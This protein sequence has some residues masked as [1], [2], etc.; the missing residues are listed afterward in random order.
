MRYIKPHPKDRDF[1]QFIW[2]IAGPH[3]F[4]A[5]Q[6]D[7]EHPSQMGTR[8]SYHCKDDLYFEMVE[9]KT[10][11]KIYRIHPDISKWCESV[12][13]PVSPLLQIY[14]DIFLSVYRRTNNKG[15]KRS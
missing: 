11:F 4:V 12:Y 3:P 14:S 5:A 6:I 9:F 2:E 1:I 8:I 7:P 10:R 15:G 13:G